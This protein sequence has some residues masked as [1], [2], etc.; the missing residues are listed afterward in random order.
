MA[1]YGAKHPC[2]CPAGG[3]GVV[4]GE[5]VS[6]NLTVTLASGELWSDDALNIRVE[7]FASGALAMETD[8]MLP[9]V[10]SVVYGCKAEGNK[11]TYNTGD[12]SPEGTLAYYR[13]ILRKEGGINKRY[14]EC[15]AHPRAKAALG[16][17]SAQTKGS[18]I[19]FQTTTTNF[20]IFADDAGDWR[21]VETFE[22][23]ASAKGWVESQTDVGTYY[24]VTVEAQG[25][26]EGKQVSTHGTVYIPSGRD[27][28]LTI[29][30]HAQVTAAYDNGAD[31][32]STITRGDGTY[33]V[34]A[35]DKDHS[36]SIIFGA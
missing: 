31:V 2:F 33:T 18:S 9:Q 8:D 22:D 7:D 12:I 26:G 20:T 11:V 3:V 4:M 5:L 19:T 14:Y 28:V 16:N 13:T 10:A 6:A 29:E 24:A 15:V 30:G 1:K 34:S 17:D 27:F 25:E 21:I 35:I 23:E 32:A 36:I